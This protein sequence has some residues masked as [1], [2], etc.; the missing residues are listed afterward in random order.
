MTTQERLDELQRLLD[1][2]GRQLRGV[3]W[4]PGAEN[5]TLEQRKKAL[6][7]MLEPFLRGE[8]EQVWFFGLGVDEMLTKK[9]W[10]ER[11]AARLVSLGGMLPIEAAKQAEDAF[12]PAFTS[13]YTP[14]EWA[15]EEMSCWGE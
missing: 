8:G 11:Y 15:D 7:D 10:C 13:D 12:D 5:L 6:A 1:T 2:T 14:E 9:Q 4:A 3:C